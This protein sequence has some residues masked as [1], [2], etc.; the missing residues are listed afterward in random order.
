MFIMALE[1]VK[2]YFIFNP[3]HLFILFL[4][5]FTMANKTSSVGFSTLRNAENKVFLQDNC[6]LGPTSQEETQNQKHVTKYISGLTEIH[7]F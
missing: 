1:V 3:F 5:S 7:F 6:R 4:P 2:F